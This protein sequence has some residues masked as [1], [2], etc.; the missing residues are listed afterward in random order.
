MTNIEEKRKRL[1]EIK[2]I[3]SDGVE[4]AVENSEDV[5]NILTEIFQGGGE[6]LESGAN[7]IGEILGGILESLS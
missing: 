4:V 2:D 3:A 5:L 1:E 7:A 6:L